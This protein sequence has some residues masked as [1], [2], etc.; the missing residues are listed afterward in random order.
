MPCHDRLSRRISCGAGHSENEVP[1]GLSDPWPVDE[2]EIGCGQDSAGVVYDFVHSDG[3]C[4]ETTP[5]GNP[6]NKSFLLPYRTQP[7]GIKLQTAFDHISSLATERPQFHGPKSQR[8]RWSSS[9]FKNMVTQLDLNQR[10]LAGIHCRSVRDKVLC[11]LEP[12]L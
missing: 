2:F 7:V 12:M 11:M 6:W 1:A 5:T 4:D 3:S 8:L 9:L 10:H